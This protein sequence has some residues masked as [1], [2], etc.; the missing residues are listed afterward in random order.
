MAEHVPGYAPPRPPKS[1]QDAAYVPEYAPPRPP[2]SD[3]ELNYVPGH[4]EAVPSK[5]LPRAP[6]SASPARSSS[7]SSASSAAAA[8]SSAA[9]VAAGATVV[10]MSSGGGG[11]GGGGGK[12][13]KSTRSGSNVEPVGGS[14]MG[15]RYD[16]GPGNKGC[17]PVRC[18]RCLCACCMCK[19]HDCSRELGEACAYHRTNDKYDRSCCCCACG[20]TG[21]VCVCAECYHDCCYAF[22]CE[23]GTFTGC[24]C[25][26][27]S[28]SD[29]LCRI[30]F[31]DMSHYYTRSFCG[32]LFVLWVVVL[33]LLVGLEVGFWLLFL[34]LIV[35]VFICCTVGG[36][37]FT[38]IKHC[39]KDPP[40]AQ[41][42]PTPTP[43]V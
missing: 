27:F 22:K 37:V 30:S 19:C 8:T 38:C 2:K 7:S 5:P 13:R 32:G 10:T 15:D 16:P 3:A 9:G 42:E 14:G 23:H 36:W 25:S 35:L 1:E 41:P 18:T 29:W 40:H 26:Y 31:G 24:R 11:G 34:L 6:S 43:V 39:S 17:G 28:C 12:K 20:A 21:F 33:L 4:A